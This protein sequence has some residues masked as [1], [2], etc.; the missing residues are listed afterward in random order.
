VFPSG[1]K[2]LLADLCWTL[3]LGLHVIVL[4]AL[5][6]LV[7]L[8]VLLL[9]RPYIITRLLLWLFVKSFYRM[10]VYG[11]ENIPASGGAL[12][13]CNH[14][15]YIDWVLLLMAQRR[16][17]RFVIFAGWTRMLVLRH[18]LR[19][20][21]AIPID[22]WS[23]PKAILKSLRNAGDAL[24]SGDVV[25]IFAEGRFTR[26][27]FL[28][29]FHRGL[30]QIVKHS[31]API[32]PVY[33]DELWGS[34]FSFYG[35]RTLWKWPRMVPYPV[36]VAFGKPMPAS[37]SAAEVRLAVQKLS[38]DC[39]LA[40]SKAC[41]SIPREIVRTA[42]RHPF[43]TCIVQPAEKEP[44]PSPLATGASQTGP[45]TYAAILASAM[46]LAGKLKKCFPEL[47]TEVGKNA[48]GMWLPP[49]ARAIQAHLAAAFCGIPIVPFAE[50][51]P[52]D[53]IQSILRQSAVRHVLSA[54]SHL[55][56]HPLPIASNAELANIQVIDL[57]SLLQSASPARRMLAQLAVCLL[58]SLIVERF[59]LRLGGHRLDD[60]A[61]ILFTHMHPSD[62]AVEPQG[63]MWSHRNLIAAASSLA[64][65]FDL[66]PRD[67]LLCTLP[68][69]QPAGLMFALWTPLSVG[70]SVLFAG[71]SLAAKAYGEL[72]TENNCTVWLASPEQ[73]LAAT[74]QC[75]PSDFRSLRL[76]ICCGVL[77]PEKT[78]T[79]AERFG[80]APL[81]VYQRPELT[82][83]VTANVPDKTLEK[84]TQIGNKPGTIGQ[85]LP[86]VACRIVHPETWEPLPADQVG[87]LVISG[88]C[89]MP[90]YWHDEAATQ[91][92]M[93][94][95]WFVTGEQARMD[96][97]GF[98]T[99]TAR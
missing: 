62:H 42:G 73:L 11:A 6:V 47:R 58:P 78:K 12:L 52:S 3:P 76:L 90:G 51:L 71:E 81:A 20:G 34:I 30:E 59:I 80:I 49:G 85:A 48:I 23:G 77:S 5:A 24:A 72:C 10:R 82:S 74:D 87:M 96:E 91:A 38:A 88:P 89:V 53:A 15:S 7:V 66:T 17:I 50:K 4:S 1:V 18:L 26:T 65:T 54:A 40:R 9:L 97:D 92:A 93:R 27:G 29:P 32:I 8:A 67:R 19:W 37:S 75:Q 22:A 95:N 63:V 84:F 13:V 44:A 79:F 68:L 33:L 36:N 2:T 46:C 70:A 21:R 64:K 14:V 99:I 57:E 94:D 31:N 43:R 86:G 98:I 83:I 45:F 55:R 61:A 16:F 41:R 69:S 25:C 56:S 28:L 39:A 60:T 35:D